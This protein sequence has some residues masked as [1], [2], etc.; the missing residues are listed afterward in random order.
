M[1]SQMKRGRR[2]SIIICQAQAL[3]NLPLPRCTKTGGA[4]S[5]VFGHGYAGPRACLVA[6]A[7]SGWTAVVLVS[8]SPKNTNSNSIVF[9]FVCTNVRNA[10]ATWMVE[11]SLQSNLYK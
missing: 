7:T 4:A 8:L 5:R 1:D 10:D 3:H 11:A 2:I 9:L 6:V